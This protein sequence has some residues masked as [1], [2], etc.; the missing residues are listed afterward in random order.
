MRPSDVIKTEIECRLGFFPPFFAPALET[1]EILENLWQQT[2]SA[3][4]DNP[5]PALFKEKL[6]VCCSRFTAHPYCIVCHSCALKGLGMTGS[7]VRN[8][9]EQP[10]PA[11]GMGIEELVSELAAE[12]A[13]LSQW[14]DP[15]SALEERFL[16]G[17]MVLCIYPGNAVRCQV[18]LRRVLGPVWYAHLAALLA[19]VKACHAWV[20]AHPELGHETDRRTQQH[21]APLLQEEP[22][23][24]NYFAE[25]GTCESRERRRA[26]EIPWLKKTH[27]V[28]RLRAS[29]LAAVTD[30]L[31][32]FLEKGDWR[33][34]SALLVKNAL[35][36]TDSEYGFI[37]GVVGKGALRI[38]AHA[39]IVWDSKVNR[40]F[41]ENALRTYRDVGYLEFT[42]LENLFGRVITSGEVVLSNDP[43]SDPRSGGKLPPGHPPLRA[44]LGVPILRGTDVVGMIGVANRPGGYTGAERGMV[45]ILSRAAGVLY[46]SY[47]RREQQAVLEN[48]YRQAERE[49]LESETL[50]RRMAESTTEVFWMA[51]TA[52]SKI[53]YV[54][55][56]YE[57]IWGRSCESLY[58]NT[59]SWAEAI[60]P[61]DRERVFA[62][63]DVLKHGG[64]FE[65][66]YRI[67]RPDGAVRWVWDRGFPLQGEASASNECA[68]IAQDI[69]ERKEAEEQ[70]KQANEQLHL[71]ASRLQ[72]VQEEERQRIAREIH[73]ELGQALTALK[74]DLTWVG[75]RL[76]RPNPTAQ[77]LGECQ[78]KIHSMEA[79]IDATDRAVQRIATA[80]RPSLLDDLGIMP[81]LEWLAQDVE[82]R[83]GV[84]CELVACPRLGQIDSSQ[85][86]AVFRIVQEAL[87]NVARHANATRVVITFGEV[88][89]MLRL[90][91][92]DNGQGINA[93]A[94]TEPSSLG[95]QGMRERTAAFGGTFAI[96]G[97][98]GK[99]TTLVAH[100]P[101]GR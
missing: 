82:T 62:S 49:L 29:Q 31:T 6:F 2:L 70:L 46:E 85:A 44:F 1:P 21:L 95:L 51:D 10:I 74:L 38:F 86:T 42:N 47:R 18:E 53:L 101:L 61:E 23:L 14:P 76:S 25:R 79:L 83:T 11:V 35:S 16:R 67:L 94:L 36:Q 7:E 40:E 43:A 9:L 34:A 55:P 3:Y 78:E 58:Q 52:F 100:I 22:H 59:M 56:A 19:Y 4:L 37:G 91:V 93:T 17:A 98:A 5:L 54:S 45:E 12:P 60:H 28:L 77:V 89:N 80:L 26:G 68:G 88:D 50:L 90:E 99:G 73:D 92:R 87:T 81:A 24:A 96:E 39:G 97:T 69:T 48:A 32:S 57:T 63:L 33:E 41:Y 30:A 75:R 84:A 27:E 15:G 13:P 8:L 65:Q 71:L 72:L 64:R 20:E 66:E